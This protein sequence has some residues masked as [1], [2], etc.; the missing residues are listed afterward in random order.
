LLANPGAP[1]SG[2]SLQ[3]HA[4]HG[5]NAATLV[6]PTIPDYL[7]LNYWWTYIHPAAVKLFE[8]GWLVD[9]I[10]WG[11]YRSLSA[12]ALDALGPRLDGRTLQ[13]AC[14]YGDLTPRLATRVDTDRGQL[15]VVDILPVQLENLRHKLPPNSQVRLLEQDSSDLAAPDATYDQALLFFLLHEQPADIRARTVAE[16]L[17]VVRPG[18]RVV[19]VDFGPPAWWHPLRYSW[20]PLISRLEPFAADLWR[21]ENGMCLPNTTTPARRRFFGGMFQMVTLTRT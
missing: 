4:I 1:L 14:V 13:V 17:R 16:T 21:A 18:G 11:N 2:H 20:L 10:L 19:I 15:D 5:H 9:L 12:A 8:R 3:G 6:P 7:R